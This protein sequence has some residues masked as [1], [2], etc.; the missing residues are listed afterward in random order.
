MVALLSDAEP[1]IIL[2]GVGSH[3]QKS[4]R[5]SVEDLG[6][7]NGNRSQLIDNY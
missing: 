3:G 6:G 2:S 5:L 7:V 4:T 1:T